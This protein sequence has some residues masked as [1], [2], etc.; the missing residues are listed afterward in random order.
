MGRVCVD[1]D[2]AHTRSRTS[3]NTLFCF[4]TDNKRNK[5]KNINDI[6]T[7][8]RTSLVRYRRP[9]TRD[10]LRKAIKHFDFKFRFFPVA[11]CERIFSARCFSHHLLCAFVLCAVLTWS[12]VVFRLRARLPLM[13][14]STH[15][16]YSH[17]FAIF[18]HDANRVFCIHSFVIVAAADAAAVL[19]IRFHKMKQAQRAARE[20]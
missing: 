1:R 13:V 5:E 15:T 20:T 17:S 8:S 9:P 14:H 11:F 2:S 10:K 12:S 19:A 16:Q 7:P 18:F 3:A 4:A 6:R